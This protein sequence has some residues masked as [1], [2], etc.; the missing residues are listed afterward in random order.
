MLRLVATPHVL[1]RITA[2]RSSRPIAV[3]MAVSVASLSLW[4][5]MMTSKS[6]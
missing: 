2:N 4:S 3:R 1:D 6:S 5:T